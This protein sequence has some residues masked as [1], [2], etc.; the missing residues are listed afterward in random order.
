MKKKHKIVYWIAT[1]WAAFGMVSTALIQ[2]FRA[3][4]GIDM[5]HHLGY[6]LY[7]LSILGTWKILGAIAILIPRHP[8][9]KEW[10]Y[11]G[12]VFAMTGA[13]VSRLYLGDSLSAILPSLF[14][15]FLVLVSWY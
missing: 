2:L 5:M 1:I 10:A 9:L 12:F 8:V 3:K 11:A 14:L 13:A 4:D 6:P 7:F 15:L